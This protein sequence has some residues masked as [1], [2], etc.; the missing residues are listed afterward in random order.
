MLSLFQHINAL[1]SKFLKLENCFFSTETDKLVI[2]LHI[3]ALN[4]NKKVLLVTVF[5]FILFPIKKIH[6]LIIKGSYSKSKWFEAN[7]FKFSWVKIHRN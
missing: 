7:K 3:S 6:I 1:F 2:F 4:F 5:D